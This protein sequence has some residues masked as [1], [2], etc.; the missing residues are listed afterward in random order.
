M[1]PTRSLI[2]TAHPTWWGVPV[3]S[4]DV[5][6]EAPASTKA[7]KRACCK[8]DSADWIGLYQVAEVDFVTSAL[9]STTSK[10]CTIPVEQTNMYC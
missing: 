8:A 3:S 7:T 1:F 10:L 4:L 9:K 5:G 6:A 2:L